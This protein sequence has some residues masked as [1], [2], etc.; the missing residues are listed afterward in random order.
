[1]G[2]RMIITQNTKSAGLTLIFWEKLK[3][4]QY[5]SEPSAVVYSAK[6]RRV[7]RDEPVPVP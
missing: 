7:L 4:V 1:M 5:T 6:Q 2:L 3:S